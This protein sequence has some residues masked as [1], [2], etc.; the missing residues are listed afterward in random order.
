MDYLFPVV[1]KGGGSMSGETSYILLNYMQVLKG[2]SL[3]EVYC[4]PHPQLESLIRG[5]TWGSGE[6]KKQ[7]L[8]QV[9]N[10]LK[11]LISFSIELETF[12]LKDT[13][14]NSGGCG[15]GRGI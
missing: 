7:V 12:K 9:T 8:K 14:K 15:K 11:E 2:V 10:L 6:G 5:F 4:C 1:K 13:F 3:R